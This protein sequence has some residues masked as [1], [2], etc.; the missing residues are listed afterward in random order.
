M[1]KLDDL[2][3]EREPDLESLRAERDR[4]PTDEEFFSTL[5]MLLEGGV[6]GLVRQRDGD[7]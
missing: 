6:R 7:L 1:S 3:R 5:S 4:M 2:V